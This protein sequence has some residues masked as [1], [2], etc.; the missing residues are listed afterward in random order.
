MIKLISVILSFINVWLRVLRPGGTRAVAA[1]NIVLRQQ[2]IALPRHHK[3]APKL[4]TFDR[5]MFG[6]LTAMINPKR[7]YRIAIVVKPATLLKFHKALIKR[8]YCLLF[9]KKS[10][11]K[12]GPKGHWF[13]HKSSLNCL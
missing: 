2:L 10:P 11:I 13:I 9:S 4:T 8:K 3:R 12:P 1:E 6:I 7:L 5:V